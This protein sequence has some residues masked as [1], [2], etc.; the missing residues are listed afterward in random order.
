G[1]F[2]RT[3]SG[4]TA[5]TSGC[6]CKISGVRS[7]IAASALSPRSANPS[8]TKLVGSA[9]KATRLQVSHSPQK[10]SFNRS[11]VAACANIR[12]S[13]YLPTP[14]APV[15]SSACGTRSARNAP[16]NAFTMRSLPTKSLK[17]ITTIS[18]H[19]STPALLPPPS[20][21]PPQSL[22]ASSSRLLAN[23]N[24]PRLS[25]PAASQVHRTWPRHLPDAANFL[26]A[27][28]VSTPYNPAHF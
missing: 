10:S 24:T 16:R 13:V 5:H 4:T 18:P 9:S 15:N 12:A 11:Q 21:F 20:I 8:C 3:G 2:N 17:P 7:T 27:N 19:A 14:P 26:R 28:H 6:V 25:S 1:V 23:Q 22:R